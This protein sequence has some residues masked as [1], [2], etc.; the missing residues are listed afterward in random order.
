MSTLIELEE[1][2]GLLPTQCAVLLSIPLPTYYQYR[3]TGKMPAV[4]GRFVRVLLSLPDDQLT[5]LI[6][7]YLFDDGL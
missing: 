2:T 6:S 3:R 4:V 1:R 5:N 7:E